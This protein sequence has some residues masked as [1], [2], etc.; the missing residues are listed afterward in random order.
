MKKAKFNSPESEEFYRTLRKRVNQYFKQKEIRKT[1][2]GSLY[3][4]AWVLFIS[5][6]GPF[7][8]LFFIPNLPVWRYLAVW[9]LMGVAMAGIGLA[10]MHDSVHGAFSPN[11]KTNDFI[12]HLSMFFIGGFVSNW[13]IQHNQLHHT[14]TNVKDLD[15]DI[16]PPFNLLRLSPDYPLETKHKL[17]HM[18]AWFLYL[19]MTVMWCTTKDIKQLLRFKR[20]GFYENRQAEYNQEWRRL[21][22]FKTGYFVFFLLLPAFLSSYSFG[23]ILSGFLLMHMVAGFILAIVFQPAHVIPTSQYPQ[24]NANNEIKNSWAGHQLIT[25]Q[26]FAMKNKWL[27]WYVGGLNFQVEHHLF[28]NISHVH[29]PEIAPIVEQTAKEYGLPYYHTKTFTRAII[30]HGKMLY[31]LGR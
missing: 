7:A 19:L 4:K 14:Y 28:P 12:G 30:D 23:L 29:Y 2:N 1:G 22:L 13:R 20:K 24:V 17:Q 27:S 11:R 8:A 18:Y 6:L 3:L 9:L 15:E 21:I 31:Q 16:N 25:T 26:N 10:I 5:M